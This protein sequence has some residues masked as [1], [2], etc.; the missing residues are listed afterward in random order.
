MKH[1]IDTLLI[2]ILFLIP[3][4]DSH[5]QS[6]PGYMGKRLSV[7]AGMFFSPAISNP[8]QNGQKS[9]ISYNRGNVFN[10]NYII[11]RNS[12]LELDYHTYKT[13]V[14]YATFFN[15]NYDNGYPSETFN[16]NGINKATD[17]SFGQISATNFAI[18]Y[19]KFKEGYLAPYGY[20]SRYGIIYNKYTVVNGNIFEKTEDKPLV[21]D[22]Y[23]GTFIS[24]GIGKQRIYF[25]FLMI[26]YGVNLNFPIQGGY[27]KNTFDVFANSYDSK[28]F[29][30]ESTKARIAGY[31]LMDVY[32]KIGF[33]L[34]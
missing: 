4:F 32:L 16:A 15:E 10:L 5:A 17:N 1:S 28:T 23:S 13:Q 3:S 7:H 30:S 29:I 21:E 27:L 20:F 12:S 31:Q 26:S 34:F 2:V 19:K 11:G 6:P 14:D 9:F 33:L 25:D 22:S 8:N 24:W 18:Y